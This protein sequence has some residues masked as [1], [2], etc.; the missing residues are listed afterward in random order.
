MNEKID[1]NE[2][3]KKIDELSK[4]HAQLD[5]ICKEIFLTLW[6]YQKL[7]FNALLKTLNKYGVKISQPTLKEHLRHMIAKELVIRKVEGFQ[8]VSY[9]LTVEVSSLLKVSEEDVK[10][11]LEA[12]RNAKNLPERLKSL[13]MNRKELFQRFTDTQL[14]EMAVKDLSDTLSLSLHELKIFIQYDLEKGRFESDAAFWKFVGNPL[15][16]MHEKSV[17]ENCRASEEY[18]KRLFE[19]IDLLI[20]ELRSD[21]ELFRRKEERRKKHFKK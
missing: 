10:G 12:R 2:R 7:R 20:N 21:K 9:S 14:D 17:A 15:Y 19:K 8:N 11:W 5:D 4:K 1:D 3:D 13:K 18:K 6:A 16:R